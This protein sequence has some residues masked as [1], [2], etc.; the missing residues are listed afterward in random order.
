MNGT[1]AGTSENRNGV[2][3]GEER[4]IGAII[5]S[6]AM[7]VLNIAGLVDSHGDLGEPA[8]VILHT[9]VDLAQAGIAPTRD[10]VVGELRRS[11]L[12]D[13]RTAC[14]LASAAGYDTSS[15]SLRCY[16]E[17]V[18]AASLRRR[19]WNW[20]TA[21]IALVDSGSERELAVTTEVF[22]AKIAEVSERL[23]SLRQ[24]IDD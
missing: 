6:P 11:G 13:R 5:R 14:W 1:S 17:M 3:Q 15:D 12:L 21:L 9:A 4:L 22:A 23:R 20:S 8:R 16:A 18:V 19:V 2:R 10:N 24:G 7:T